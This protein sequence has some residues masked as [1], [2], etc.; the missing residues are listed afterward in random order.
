MTIHS[1]SEAERQLRM[2]SLLGEIEN[3]V[4]LTKEKEDEP[5]EAHIQI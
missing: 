3:P 2:E 5:Q 4:D 1:T